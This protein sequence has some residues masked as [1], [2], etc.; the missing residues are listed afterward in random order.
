MSK[1]KPAMT[2]VSQGTLVLGPV[3]FNI[4]IVGK[5]DSGTEHTLSTF[6]GDTKLCGAG[7]TVEE[8]DVNHRDLDR[9]DRRACVNLMKIKNTGKLMVQGNPKHKYRLGEEWIERSPAARTLRVLVNEYIDISQQCVL[10]AQ[11]SAVSWMAS[12]AA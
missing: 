10:A 5:M 9:L 12:K 8:G 2:G 4:F 1:W 11:R 3:L 6:V 7:N